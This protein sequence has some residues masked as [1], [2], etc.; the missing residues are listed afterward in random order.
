M[1]ETPKML[2]QLASTPIQHNKVPTTQ[3]ELRA[4][5][6]L[7]GPSIEV[8]LDNALWHKQVSSRNGQAVVEQ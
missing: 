7:N 1:I 5:K 4:S 8:N 3:R 6:R 2:V